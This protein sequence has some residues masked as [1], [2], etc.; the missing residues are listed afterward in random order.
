ML[1][2]QTISFPF[3]VLSR[4]NQNIPLHMNEEQ[5]KLKA[6]KTKILLDKK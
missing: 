1:G 4:F 3:A 5:E 2:K 6:R